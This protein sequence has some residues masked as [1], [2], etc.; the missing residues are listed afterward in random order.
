ME[1]NVVVPFTAWEQAV[2]VVLFVLVVVS[3]LRWFGQQQARWQEFIGKRDDQWQGFLENQREI[4]N[5][6][7]NMMNQSM[8]NLTQVT[9]LLVAEVQEMR[10]DFRVHDTMERELLRKPKHNP[11]PKPILSVKGKGKTESQGAKS[12][13]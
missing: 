4:D 3:M 9:T 13:D 2:F 7:Y 12:G 6:R 5:D 1:S 10:S 8:V 11:V